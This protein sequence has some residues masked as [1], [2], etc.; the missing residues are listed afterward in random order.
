MKYKFLIILELL[1]IIILY[2]TI[3]KPKFNLYNI[4]NILGYNKANTITF[5]EKNHIFNSTEKNMVN[6]LL[7]YN[8]FNNSNIIPEDNGELMIYDKRGK[9]T[10]RF[11]IFINDK[12]EIELKE[13]LNSMNMDFGGLY[14]F[15]NSFEIYINPSKVGDNKNLFEIS[16]WKRL[17]NSFKTKSINNYDSVIKY[18]LNISENIRKNKLKELF[19][20]LKKCFIIDIA[21]NFII[22][23]IMKTIKKI[24]K[25]T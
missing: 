7:N 12:Y 15:D 17:P 22:L 19:K 16:L 3:I 6:N 5:Y 9:I 13:L 20:L 21:I 2:Q 4:Y 23:V 8:L 10:G 25:L 24:D 11:C 1:I 18:F 14:D